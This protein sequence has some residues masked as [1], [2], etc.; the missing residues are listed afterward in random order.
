MRKVYVDIKATV[1]VTIDESTPWG[2][3]SEDLE[4]QMNTALENVVCREATVEVLDGV[5]TEVMDSK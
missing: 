3:F 1:L 5:T 2:E 4:H